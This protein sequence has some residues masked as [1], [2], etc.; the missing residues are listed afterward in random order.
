MWL[1]VG[2]PDFQP[3]LRTLGLDEGSDVDLFF[4]LKE[5]PLR[6][7]PSFSSPDQSRTSHEYNLCI[8]AMFMMSSKDVKYVNW[9]NLGVLNLCVR[10]SETRWESAV[11]R[12][13]PDGI[14]VELATSLMM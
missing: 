9:P 6:K 7:I 2:Q 8:L 12:R 1:S 10:K 3:L 11:K 4:S 5:S 13:F 14:V